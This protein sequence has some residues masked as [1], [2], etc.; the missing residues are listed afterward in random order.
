MFLEGGVS[1]N[2]SRNI[3]MNTTLVELLNK[4][5]DRAL[6]IILRTKEQETDRYVP[7]DQSMRLRKVI[8]DQVN[9]FADFATDVLTSFES[10]QSEVVLNDLWLDKLDAIYEAVVG[11]E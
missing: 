7:M 5:R 2:G 3:A 6:A 10:G 4:R 9:A 1:L 11:D 8:L